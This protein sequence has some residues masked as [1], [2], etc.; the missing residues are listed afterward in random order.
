MASDPETAVT[1]RLTIE[2]VEHA[3][4]SY[5]GMHKKEVLGY[6]LAVQLADTMR[7]NER[8]RNEIIAMIKHF[9]GWNQL[10]NKESE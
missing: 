9:S 3:I 7:E 8:L 4:A 6:A 5:T 1:N 2:D 10:S